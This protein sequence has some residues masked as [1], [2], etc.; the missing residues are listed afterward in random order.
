MPIPSRQTMPVPNRTPPRKVEPQSSVLDRITNLG[1]DAADGLNFMLYGDSGSGKTTLWSSFPKPILA[2]ICSGG[3][4]PGEL[5]SIDTP[6]MKKVVSTVTLQTP[7]ELDEI[8]RAVDTQALIHKGSGKPFATIILDHVSGFQDLKL[9]AYKGL[10]SV[11]QQK[12]FGIATKQ[13]WGEITG[14]LKEHLVKLLSLH[15]NVVVI[16]QERIFLPSGD[17][18]AKEVKS[19]IDMSGVL[20]PKVGA[21]LVPSLTGWLNPACDYVIQTFI[22]QRRIKEESI[23]KAGGKEIRS[24]VE[25]DVEGVDF[26]AR[27]GKHEIFMTKFR[28]PDAKLPDV[29][30]LGDSANGVRKKPTGYEQIMA[31]INGG[32]M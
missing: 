9:M 7:S 4:K 23:T 1:F 13:D 31:L 5:R 2:V 20:K 29:I 21:A 15:C 14:Q 8:V 26:C 27:T 12:S 32:Q 28:V 18:P 3:Q 6:E 19:S 11:P 16:A 17:D 25:K 24:V 10:S 22:R 30:V